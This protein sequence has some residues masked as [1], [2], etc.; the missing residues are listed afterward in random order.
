MK[1][2]DNTFSVEKAEDSSGFIMAGNEF[3]AGK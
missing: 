1:P 3:V 2:N